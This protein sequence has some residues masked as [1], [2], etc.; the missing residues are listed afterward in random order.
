VSRFCCGKEALDVWLRLHALKS[1][2]RSSRSY[3]VCDGHAAVGYYCLATAAVKRDHAPAKLRRNVPDPLP[4]LVLGRLAV[5]SAYSGRG[6][7]AALIKDAMRRATEVSAIV[8]SRA[9]LVHAIDQDA[10]SF[11]LKYGFVEFPQE[12][13]SLFLPT[14]SIAGAST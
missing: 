3:V 5:D 13:L 10:R 4:L 9:L 2:G 7:G 12:S 14:E 1:E 6:I 8:G 11:Y